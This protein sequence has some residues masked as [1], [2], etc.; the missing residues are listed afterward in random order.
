MSS[1]YDQALGI[2][3]EIAA[4]K[5]ERVISAAVDLFY[6]RGYDN[7]TLD[8]VAEQLGVTKPFIYSHFGSKAEL[9]AEICS[10]GINSSQAALDSVLVLPDSPTEKLALICARFVSAVLESQKHIAIFAREAKN[11]NDEDLKR[12]STQRRKFDR[13]LTKLL[14]EG[15]AAG[16]FSIGDTHFAALAIQG[17]IS[18]A[19]VWYRPDGRLSMTEL[20][21]QMAELVLRLVG[22][23]PKS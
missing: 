21:D 16:E 18:W 4:L 3:G 13:A 2:K 6:E 19:Y 14:D 17:M 23:A 7:T 1:R 11:L 15:V 12:I 9:L 20:S 5:R 22:T 10:R 8:A